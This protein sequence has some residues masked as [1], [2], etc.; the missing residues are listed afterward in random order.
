MSKRRKKEGGMKPAGKVIM[1]KEKNL[2]K[3]KINLKMK[4]LI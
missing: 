4:Y 1:N 3:D 2:R